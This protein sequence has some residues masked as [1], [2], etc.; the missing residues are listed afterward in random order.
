MSMVMPSIRSRSRS[1]ADDCGTIRR[2]TSLG[3][4]NDTRIGAAIARERRAAGLGVESLAAIM[5]VAPDDLLRAEAG[6]HH[7]ATLQVQ[8]AASALGVPISTLLGDPQPPRYQLIQ[9]GKA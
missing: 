2:A 4:R 8:S 9:G 1:P 5:R 3:A 7:L 6:E